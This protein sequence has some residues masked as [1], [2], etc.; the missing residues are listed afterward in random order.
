[1]ANFGA[2]RNLYLYVLPAPSVKKNVFFR[3]TVLFSSQSLSC[4]FLHIFVLRVFL[5]SFEELLAVAHF[6]GISGKLFASGAAGVWFKSPA[7]QISHKMPTTCHRC[8]LEVCPNSGAK[9]RRWAPLT[10]DTWNSI[11]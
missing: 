4:L 7:D 3:A 5:F 9:L 8:N 11:L 1:L 2:K 6:L 10:R